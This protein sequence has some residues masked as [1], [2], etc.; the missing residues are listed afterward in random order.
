MKTQD[1][2]VFDTMQAHTKQSL[3]AWKSLWLQSLGGLSAGAIPSASAQ[4]NESAATQ[5]ER[6]LDGLKGYC[7]WLESVSTASA[8]QPAGL[9]WRDAMSKVF[10]G[11]AHPFA[12]AFG[13]LPGM[14]ALA[15]MPW[16]QGMQAMPNAMPDWLNMPAFGLHR[17]HQEQAQALG[18]AWV[19][20]QERSASYKSLLARAGAQAAERLQDMLAERDEPGRQVESL[21]ALYDLWIDAAE[22]AWAEIAMSDEYRS[23]Y[24]A[25]VNAQT[26]LRAKIQKQTEQSAMQMGMPTRSEVNSLGERLQSLRRKLNAGPDD[27]LAAE[28]AELRAEVAALRKAQRRD[29]GRAQPATTPRKAPVKKAASGNSVAKKPVRAAA[30]KSASKT[31]KSGAKKS[32]SRTRKTS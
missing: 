14:D 9:P 27:T 22:E 32:A 8:A 16:L 3:E 11:G 29:E 20:Y 4:L 21:R 13:E 18:K 26:R 15:S 25:M 31:A 10:A 23:V 2:N 6:S 19:E 28:V 30:K 17:E 7:Q 1:E 5:L 12:Q 24:A